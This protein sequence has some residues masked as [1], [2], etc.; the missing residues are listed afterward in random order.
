MKQPLRV[1]IDTNL[2][3]SALVFPSGQLARLRLLWQ[4][5]QI[6]P[7]VSQ[8]TNTELIRAQA[9]PKFRL[10]TAAQKEPLADYLPYCKTVL[11]AVPPPVTPDCRDDDD[12]PFL[13]L[14]VAGKADVLVS[15]DKYLLALAGTFVCPIVTASQFLVDF[16]DEG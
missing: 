8:V 12:L 1:A 13:Q 9:Y 15:G 3:L 6:E 5:H 16:T 2:F 7:L 10:I 11:M 14:A 4:G